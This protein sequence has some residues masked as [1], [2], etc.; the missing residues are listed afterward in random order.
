MAEYNGIGLSTGSGIAGSAHLAN[1]L[2]HGWSHMSVAAGGSLT[3]D[4]ATLWLWSS[5]SG[6]DSEL[7]IYGTAVLGSTGKPL[8]IEKDPSSSDYLHGIIYESGAT[9]AVEELSLVGAP[10]QLASTN[11]ITVVNTTISGVSTGI[12][13]SGS[14]SPIIQGCNLGGADVSVRVR[15]SASPDLGG[16]GNSAGNN[17]LN[18]ATFCIDNQS[19]GDIAAQ[20]NWWGCT[21][22]AQMDAGMS[23]ITAIH[24]AEDGPYGSVDFS[25]W[26]TGIQTCPLSCADIILDTDP[27]CAGTAQTL[28]AQYRYQ[29]G[30]TSVSWDLDNDAVFGDSTTNPTTETLPKGRNPISAQISDTVS[31]CT[32]ETTATVQPTGAPLFAG[33]SSVESLNSGPVGLRLDWNQPTEFCGLKK[34]PKTTA[35]YNIYRSTSP[36]LVPGSGTLLAF[37]QASPYFIDTDVL[38]A[39]TY[40]YVVRAESPG[41]DGSGPCNGGIEDINL[42]E[43]WG[44][45]PSVVGSAPEDV[46]FLTATAKDGEITLDWFNPSAGYGTTRI[47]R[48]QSSMPEG[49]N[50]PQALCFDQTGTANHVD[51]QLLTGLTNDTWYRFGAWVNNVADASGDWSGGKFVSAKPF[52]TSGEVKWAYST[53]ATTMSPPGVHPGVANFIASN[54]R[55]LHSTDVGTGGGDWPLGWAPVSMNAPAQERP[56]VIPFGVPTVSGASTVVFLGSQDGH[57]YA[58]DAESGA[59]LW[60]SPLLG[61]GVQASPSG[62]FTAFSAPHD[63]ILVGSRTPGGNSKFYGLELSSGNIAWTFDNGG[64]SNAIGIISSQAW[65]DSTNS[66]VYF[67]SRQKVG[68]SQDTLWCL[69]FDDANASRLWSRNIGASDSAPTLRNGILY[70]GNNVGEVHALDPA[71]GADLWA[72]PYASHDGAVKGYIWVEESGGSKRLY[73]ST[74]TRVYGLEDTGSS[75][76]ELWS[77]VSLSK[78]SPVVL[79]DSDVYVGSSSGNGSLLRLDGSTGVQLGSMSLG[80][81]SIATIVGGP[82]YDESTH[83]LVVGTEEGIVYSVQKGF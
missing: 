30:S 35:V 76:S 11:V 63:L 64:G 44:T 50:D 69:N 5:G 46:S 38:G 13:I 31:N 24:D 4:N 39:T 3:I 1:L 26:L 56:I 61:T 36:G 21:S 45:T 57:V 80:D 17:L 62:S 40:Y 82:T 77:P 12:E 54:D 10:L 18:G 27:V 52:D 53:A 65:V 60:S 66:R 73:F 37:C 19:T 70:A 20:A 42:I 72:A 59:E 51:S 15:D 67:T 78:P 74:A 7:Q 43:K 2:F 14:G 41:G 32:T 47:C 28:T 83:Q 49:P 29:N 48:R 9:G 34:A 16:G 79:V 58:V 23:N 55:L 33:L 8:V 75:V 6:G 22:T 81:P 25:A 71:T 68:G